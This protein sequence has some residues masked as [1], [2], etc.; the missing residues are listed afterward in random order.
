MGGSSNLIRTHRNGRVWPSNGSRSATAHRCLNTWPRSNVASRL[1]R[2]LSSSAP[3]GR[4]LLGRTPAASI[5]STMPPPRLW[6]AWRLIPNGHPSSAQALGLDGPQSACSFAEMKSFGVKIIGSTKG[7]D[8]VEVGIETVQRQ[9]LWLTEHS[10]NFIKDFR[11]Y[12]WKLDKSGRLLNVPEHAFSH[13]PDADHRHHPA[14]AGGVPGSHCLEL[15]RLL[16]GSGRLRGRARC[17]LRLRL[18]SLAAVRTALRTALAAR[19]RRWPGPAS[20]QPSRAASAR[21]ASP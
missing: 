3:T 1:F 10:I 17:L 8:S 7:P 15:L 2:M 4:P 19:I 16:P 11:N 12:L 21:S 13:V 18:R 5:R 9:Q 20:R 6:A 14:A